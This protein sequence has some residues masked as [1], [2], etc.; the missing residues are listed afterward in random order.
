MENHIP[1]LDRVNFSDIKSGYYLLADSWV[2]KDGPIL[3]VQARARYLVVYL[4][5]SMDTGS[6]TR[7]V[8]F[9]DAN[10][11]NIC[12]YKRLETESYTSEWMMIGF[13][14]DRLQAGCYSFPEVQ[15]PLPNKADYSK[16]RFIRDSKGQVIGQMCSV[17]GVPYHRARISQIGGNKLLY[18]KW[19]DWNKY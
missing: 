6:F 18:P 3:D 9:L 11:Q 15:N 13:D 4:S 7:T 2:G 1:T 10:S 5:R 8:S 19:G 17:D 16:P 14:L 12:S